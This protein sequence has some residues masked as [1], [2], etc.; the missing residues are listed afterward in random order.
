MFEKIIIYYY[1]TIFILTFALS[2][3]S[4]PHYG[5]F[6]EIVLGFVLAAFWPIWFPIAIWQVAKRSKHE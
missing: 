5:A 4:K 1:A 6:S 2:L 3:Y